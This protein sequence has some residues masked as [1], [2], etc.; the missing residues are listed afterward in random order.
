M[1]PEDD[2][3]LV[4]TI[5]QPNLPNEAPITP[6]SLVPDAPPAAPPQGPQK[7][8]DAEPPKA[9]SQAKRKAKKEPES[10]QEPEPVAPKPTTAEALRVYALLTRIKKDVELLASLVET[11]KN[12]Q[13][14]I[15]ELWA[16]AREA[17]PLVK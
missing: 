12:M 7:P 14:H 1:S 11:P 15:D 5:G 17:C 9:K 10:V 2:P 6:E 3:K 13:K 4:D 8:K 16:A